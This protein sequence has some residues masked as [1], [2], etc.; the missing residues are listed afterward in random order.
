MGGSAAIK[1]VNRLPKHISVLLLDSRDPTS[2]F[3]HIDKKPDNVRFWRNVLPGDAK[4]FTPEDKHKNTNYFGS[5]NAANIFMML[6]RP[7]G[8]CSGAQNIVM[9]NGDHHEVGRY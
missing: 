7:W 3:G 2:W 4:V 9:P 8:T 5:M 6:G 1:F